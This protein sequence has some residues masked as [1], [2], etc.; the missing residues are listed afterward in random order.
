MIAYVLSCCNI[1]LLEILQNNNMHKIYMCW[2]LYVLG[3]AILSARTLGCCFYQE[4]GLALLCKL[5]NTGF[6]QFMGWT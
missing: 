1:L 4:C 6:F 3:V 5:H 2:P